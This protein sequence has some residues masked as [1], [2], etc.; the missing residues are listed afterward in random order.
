MVGARERLG[1]LAPRGV[2]GAEKKDPLLHP[3]ELK[4]PRLTET[5][6]RQGVC[7]LRFSP[8]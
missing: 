7:R 4:P 3:L 1:H 5:L 8:A 6:S 2:A